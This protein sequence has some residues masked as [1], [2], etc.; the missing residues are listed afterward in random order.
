MIYFDYAAT[1]PPYDEVIQ[2]ITEVMKRHYGN[3][4]SI[5]RFGEEAQQLLT[6]A[7][8]VTAAALGVKP[9]EIIF[10]SGATE[11]N[12]LA[13]KGAA[14]QYQS[15]GRHIVTV[16]T[17][18]PSVLES[19]LQMR[20]LGCEVTLLPVDREGHIDL[21]DLLQT[22]RKD[23]VLVSIMHVNNE[24]GRVQLLEEIGPALKAHYPRV[25]LHVDGVQGFGKLPVDLKRW[26]ADLYSLSA[27]KIRGPK[28]AGLLYVKEGLE[29]FPL[30][31]GGSQERGLRSGT[32]N[33]PLLVGMAKAM[34]MAS[35]QQQQYAEHVS[36]L[37]DR[38]LERLSAIPVLEM[39]SGR[40]APHIV[41]VSHPGMKAEVILHS[42]EEQGFA[43]STKSACSSK[44]PEPSRVLLE[45]GRDQAQASGGIRISLGAEHTDQD[46][47]R[48]GEALEQ[49]IHKLKPLERWT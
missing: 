3:P 8:E 49:I 33:I 7:R 42:L 13:I 11:S 35:A 43:V 22:V 37:R 44:R 27:H 5:H 1:T 21:N 24:T 29:L 26:Q 23:T 31:A 6:K 16:G 18:H 38:L 19:C 45:M 25:L 48:L 39:N 47:D 17:E 28:G 40:E 14:F 20:E 10:T 30:L 41:H 15:R 9:E 4:S 46:I 32:E 34:R 12:N 36:A 2:T